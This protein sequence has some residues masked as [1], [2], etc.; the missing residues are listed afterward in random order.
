MGFALFVQI[1]ITDYHCTAVKVCI[2]TF[3]IAPDAFRQREE[4]LVSLSMIGEVHRHLQAYEE[5]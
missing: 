1:P 2:I 5:S 4:D 3:A